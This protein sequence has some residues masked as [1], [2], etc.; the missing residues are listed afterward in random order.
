MSALRY[1]TV[2]FDLDGTLTQSEDGIIRSVRYAAEQLGRTCEDTEALKAFIGPPLYVSF[3][4]R[5]GMSDSEAVEAQRLYRVR[6]NQIGWSENRVY[7]GIP[8]LLR[9]LKKYGIRTGVTT[10]KPQDFA[11]RICR[12]FGLAPYLD[13]IIGPM[14]GTKSA[15]KQVIVAEGMSR[16][17]GRCVV[18]GDRKFDVE[19][20]KANGI[21]CIGVTYGYGSEQELTQ[22]GATAVASSVRELQELLLPGMEP[23]KGLFVSLEG[24]DGCG[25]TTQ[26]EVLVNWL[27]ERGWEITVT[28]EPG[29]DPIAEK[30]RA[31]ILDPANT[32]M[33]DVTEAYLYAASRA[34]NVRT[35]VRPALADGRLV[36][37]D[38]FVDSSIAY[39][40]GGRGLGARKIAQLNAGA[41]DGCM[42]DLTVYLE[43]PA[44]A[45]LA[46]RLNA[47]EPDRLER[48]K[49]AFWQR[50]AEAY[51]A[52]YADEPRVIRVDASGSI[53]SVSADLKAALA[54]RFSV[55]MM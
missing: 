29:G 51:A 2:L 27:S 42:P 46:R 40:G 7:P 44:E 50:T 12:H 14:P 3:R 16:L 21:E 35:V 37:C 19:G 8:R 34:Q 39:Q 36:V 24:M 22:A 10:G 28:R 6:Y 5:M 20:A 41:V 13:T 1:D 15:D 52:L 54:E 43:M 23:A 18:V 45:A 38:R 55:P 25:K 47:G 30:I 53:E 32:Q 31:I 11:E 48:E 49:D 4:E 33:A 26:R 17:G 9:T